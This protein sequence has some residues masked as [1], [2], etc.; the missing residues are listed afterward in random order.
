MASEPVGEAEAALNN[1]YKAIPSMSPETGM[2]LL[3]SHRNLE[4]SMQSDAS[5]KCSTQY[6][7]MSSEGQ[8][9]SILQQRLPDLGGGVC[10]R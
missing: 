3:G 8:D 5:P 6:L 9:N 4:E 7:Q 2:L 1:P 10:I